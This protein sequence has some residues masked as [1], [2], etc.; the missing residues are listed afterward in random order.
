MTVDL[1]KSVVLITT[2]S[3]GKNPRFGTGFIIR[4]CRGAAYVVTCAHVVK[5]RGSEQIIKADDIPAKVIAS[6]EKVGIDLAVLRVEGLSGSPL[7]CK[8][9]GDK[10]KAFQT[11]GFQQMQGE[12]MVVRTLHGNL[13]E[14]VGLQSM[15]SRQRVYAWDLRITDS[16]SLQ[17]GYSGSPILDLSSGYVLGV[18][19]HRLDEGNYGLAIS[20]EALAEFWNDIES[21]DLKFLLWGL[22]YRDQTLLFMQML[23]RES[24]AAL[25]IYGLPEYG[26]KWLLNR[27]V[28]QYVPNSINGQII[29]VDLTRRVRRSSI[30]AL[31][32]DIADHLGL[33]GSDH[34]LEE[35]IDGVCRWWQTQDVFLVFHKVDSIAQQDFHSLIEKFWLPL[36]KRAMDLQSLDNTHRLLMFLVDYGDYSS[37]FKI[38]FVEKLDVSWNPQIP[39]RSPKIATF[40][41]RDLMDWIQGV[42]HKLPADLTS[43]PSQFTQ[44]ILEKSYDGVPELALDEICYRFGYDWQEEQG[45]WLKL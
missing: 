4:R 17:P 19:S 29:R 37:N 26:Q 38:P 9:C 2:K 42:Y 39:V 11:A 36:V 30:E 41:N 22:G 23:E 45:K 33:V 14:K 35:I 12:H 10:D 8:S 3:D 43:K 1:T 21:E 16:Y 18:V 7:N 6:G 25:L 20:I 34:S 13:G 24:V 28:E 40:S 27:L 44:A 15:L 32:D 5:D 31:W